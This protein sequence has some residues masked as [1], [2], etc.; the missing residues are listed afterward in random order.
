M[1]VDTGDTAWLLVSAALVLFMTPGLA[2]FYGG[3]VRSKHVLTMLAQNF[4]VIAVVSIVWAAFAYS[5]AFGLSYDKIASA[6]ISIMQPTLFDSAT[7]VWNGDN[8]AKPALLS[9]IPPAV[10]TPPTNYVCAP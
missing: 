5:F 2:I 7:F 1:H 10:T 9:Q 4:A 6:P 3:M 8:C